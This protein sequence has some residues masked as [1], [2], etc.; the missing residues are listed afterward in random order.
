MES[1]EF[2]F[3]LLLK[4]KLPLKNLNDRMHVPLLKAVFMET[5][6]AHTLLTI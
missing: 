1:G 6:V 3:Y 4:K 2:L 5:E